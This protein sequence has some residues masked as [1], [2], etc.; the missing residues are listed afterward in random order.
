MAQYD[1]LPENIYNADEKGFLMG[2]MNRTK[3]VFNKHYKKTGQL[4]GAV[5]DGSRNWIT[6]LACICQDGSALPPFLIYQGKEGGF[7]DSWCDD[8]DPEHHMAFFAT[9]P[10]GWTSHDLGREWL[11]RVFDRY[12]R[13]KARNGRDYRL[14]IV[15]GHSSHINMA[16]LEWC[17][18]HRIIVAVF[19]PH[20]THRLQ[21]LDVSLFSPLSTA[22][23][24]EL[25]KWTSKTQGLVSMSKR[26]FWN[27]FWAAWEASFVEKNVESGWRRTGLRPFDPDVVLSQLKKQ[28]DPSSDTDSNTSTSSAALEKPTARQLRRLIDQ[29]APKAAN[30]DPL[31]RK[32]KNTI[33][34]LQSEVEILR[35]ENTGLRETVV[36][37][38]RRRQRSKPLKDY[39]F[40]RDDPNSAQIYSPNKIAEARRRKAEIEAQQA[41]EA[42]Q[43]QV[44]KEE[45]QRVALEKKAQVE[46]RKKQ[47]EEARLQKLV[48]KEEQQRLREANKQLKEDE[49][50][51]KQQ[52]AQQE[53]ERKQEERRKAQ[54]GRLAA[55]Q[56]RRE[57]LKKGTASKDDIQ[58]P[59]TASG[60]MQLASTD[61]HEISYLQAAFPIRTKSP[62]V[63]DLAGD[64]GDKG[65][66]SISA[67]GRPRRAQR[68]P[69]WLDG[70]EI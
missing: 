17:E 15:D 37:E 31:V 25:V 5:Q 10:N 59:K 53:K 69:K 21:P 6:L 61:N 30:S 24:S 51:R 64:G 23:T 55:A 45:K 34:S 68:L 18:M 12:S 14:L 38:K 47:R 58:R 52:E 39:L 16:F 40:D 56:A 33:D 42:L 19:P 35:L 66:G 50:R 27:I 41:N 70:Y 44:Q 22:Y 43:K 9:S 29:V 62:V 48:E 20:S 60:A 8:V 7:R 57:A 3:R 49:R 26:N 65:G 1:I 67:T 32:L 36:E 46:E 4:I 54:E 28:P 63:E 11:M 13:E 2:V